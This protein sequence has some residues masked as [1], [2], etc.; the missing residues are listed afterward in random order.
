MPDHI[1]GIIII[2]PNVGTPNLGVPTLSNCNNYKSGSLGVIINQFKRVCTIY[3]R[4]NKIDFNCQSRFHDHIIRNN[5]EFL[6]IKNY[7]VNNPI[8]WNNGIENMI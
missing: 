7:I 1:Y 5:D 3:A 6:K 4:N 8:N 2:G